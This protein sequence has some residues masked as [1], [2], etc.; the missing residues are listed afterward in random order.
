[1]MF[2]N[3]I[4]TISSFSHISNS[5]VAL[6]SACKNIKNCKSFILS[7]DSIDEETIFKIKKNYSIN[8]IDIKNI[9]TYNS[10]AIYNKYQKKKDLLRWSSKPSSCLYF[11]KDYDNVIYIDNDIFFT[12]DANF[13]LPLIN[14][15]V[16]LT[17]H[18]RPTHPFKTINQKI[19]YHTNNVYRYNQ[20]KALFTDGFFNAGFFACSNKGIDAVEWWSDM[21]FLDCSISKPEGIYLDQKYLDIMALNFS[22]KISIVN[23]LGCNIAHWNIFELNFDK[24]TPIF[25]HFSGDKETQQIHPVLQ[26]NYRIYHDS[27]TETQ[28]ILK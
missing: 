21:V 8:I 22:D 9:N 25:F 18:N 11:L 5:I 28:A 12:S 20:F 7:V 23:N 19:Y 13:I 2:N 14:K 17:R 3:C 26:E 27:V 6:S 24:V 4:F 15:G 1:M 16:C 10:L